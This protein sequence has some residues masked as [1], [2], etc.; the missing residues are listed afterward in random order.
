MTFFKVK[1]SKMGPK[2]AKFDDFKRERKTFV[3]LVTAIC[4]VEI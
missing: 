3:A 2:M 4:D 1:R